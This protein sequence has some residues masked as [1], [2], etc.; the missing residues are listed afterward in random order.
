[1]G[2]ASLL[3]PSQPGYNNINIIKSFRMLV[4]GN[5]RIVMKGKQ[6]LNLH[7]I[8]FLTRE[9]KVDPNDGKYFGNLFDAR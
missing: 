3:N 2:S 7:V 9:E 4:F 8:L 1:M 5:A 6:I